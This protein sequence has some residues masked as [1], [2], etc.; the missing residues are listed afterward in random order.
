MESSK[1]CTKCGKSK[2]LGEFYTKSKSRGGGPR[3][4]CIECDLAPSRTPEGRAK[5]KARTNQWVVKNP[6]K[7]QARV[8]KH[9]RIQRGQVNDP[10]RPEPLNCECCGEVPTKMFE[11]HDHSTGL[12]RGWLCHHCNSGLGL[13]KDSE[14]RLS[15]AIQYLR[16]YGIHK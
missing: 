11:D 9:R 16:T 1:T 8:V 13:F 4:S 15:Q 2:S 14:D 12:F 5:A 3:S 7:Y 10:T 6:E